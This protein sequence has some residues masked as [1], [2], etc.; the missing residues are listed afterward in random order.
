MEY[1]LIYIAAII[2]NSQT[3]I[4]MSFNNVY[5]VRL[6]PAGSDQ[7]DSYS[8]SINKSR[9]S[10]RSAVTPQ[11]NLFFEY[12]IVVD[13]TV[14]INFYFAYG[15]NLPDNLLSQYIIIFYSQLVN[16]V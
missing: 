5:F 16:S 13:S 7:S 1:K 9:R 11:N 15:G 14:F 10:K 8:N 6:I 2:I 4:Q 3:G 12:L